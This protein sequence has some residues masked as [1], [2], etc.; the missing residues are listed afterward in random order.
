MSKISAK[1]PI[2][3]QARIKSKRLPGKVF[4]SLGKYSILDTLISRISSIKKKEKRIGQI[5]L[6][7][8]KGEG[9][10]FINN[11]KLKKFLTIYEGSESN[12]IKR[13]STV[14]KK[15]NLKYFFRLTADS[16][17]ICIDAFKIILDDLSYLDRYDCISLYKTKNF[18]RGSVISLITKRYLDKALKENC[19]VTNE[20]LVIGSSDTLNRL[21]YSPKYKSKIILPKFCIDD[22]NEYIHI[23]NFFKKNKIP[24]SLKGLKN[25]HDKY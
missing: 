24:L 11:L 23:L 19:P 17:L 20:H 6:A 5:Y 8:P 3:I 18:P 14:V 13:F 2:I 12:L 1:I 10:Y 4:L 22:I 9:V 15:N 21:I 25:I 16:P 7:V